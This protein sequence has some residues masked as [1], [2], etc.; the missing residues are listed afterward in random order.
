MAIDVGGLTNIELSF[1]VLLLLSTGQDAGH[2]PDRPLRPP[3]EGLTIPWLYFILLAAAM[4]AATLA[5]A[6]ATQIM[7]AAANYHGI[8]GS[9]SQQLR[10]IGVLGAVQHPSAREH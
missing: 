3:P 9:V 5:A 4:L 10:S 7:A 8:E 1:A 2:A 6:V